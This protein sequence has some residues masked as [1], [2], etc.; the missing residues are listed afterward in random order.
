MSLITY[1]K[2][3]NTQ[4]ENILFLHG[5][6]ESIEAWE[7]F[8][9]ELS[10]YF[11]CLLYDFPGHGNHQ[12]Y[13]AEHINFKQ[14][15]EDIVLTLTKE[16]ITKTHV[17]CHSMGGYFGCELKHRY[18]SIIKKVLLSNS[19]LETDTEEQLKKRLKINRIIKSNLPLLCKV[20][21]SELVP[22]LKD[23]KE[24]VCLSCNPNHLIEYQKLFALR[25]EYFEV[26][27]NYTDDFFFVFGEKDNQIPWKTTK[28]R[29]K[30]R[31]HILLNEGHM[32]PL[33][34][35]TEWTSVVLEFLK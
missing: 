14:I 22:S 21:F 17:V 8:L 11:N 13:S 1:Y 18:P 34:S 15:S 7:P 29:T 20:S 26:Y 25:K 23:I 27:Q 33:N 9:P 19:T 28:E 2:P 10:K 30:K 24:R 6:L 35:I 5:F 32:L 12:N 31:Q 4:K 3:H 16:N